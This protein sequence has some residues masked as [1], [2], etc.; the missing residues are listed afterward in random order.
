MDA[1]SLHRAVE[2]VFLR[3]QLV[4]ATNPQTIRDH[5]MGNELDSTRRHGKHL[6]VHA[7]D[8]WL[9]LH[10]GMT[11]YLD[12]TSSDEPEDHTEL[13]LE[14]EDGRRLSYVNERKFGAVSWADDVDSFVEEHDLG[15]DPLA[16]RMDRAAFRD[17]LKDRSGSIKGTLMNQ[18]VVAGLGNVYTDESLFQAGIHPESDTQAL[19]D[20]EQADLFSVMMRLI[21]TAIERGADV[22]ELPDSWLLPHREP[23]QRCPRD[24]GTIERITVSGR[25]TYLCADHQDLTG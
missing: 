12:A 6:F 9:R 19:S 10:F 2:E 4:E 16:D 11:G 13:L 7:G 1:T 25:A 24:G 21:D 18:S 3:E 22:E 14:F 8:G 17:R 5:L 20:E 15:P 23:G